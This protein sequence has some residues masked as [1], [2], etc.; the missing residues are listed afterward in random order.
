MLKLNRYKL[1]IEYCGTRYF[2]MQ[3]QKKLP[4]IESKLIDAISLFLNSK[5]EIQYSGRTDRGVHAKG[6]VIHFDTTKELNEYQIKAGINYYLTQEDIVIL[7]VEKV[8]LDF[9]ARFSAQERIYCYKILNRT[10][11][12]TFQKNLS[13][14]FRYRLDVEKMR[15]ASKYLIGKHDF[16]AFRSS[17][18]QKNPIKTLNFIKIEKQEDVIEFK[19]GAKS[20]LHNMVR[21][22]V[23][24]LL[25]I[26]RGKIAP[27]KIQELLKEKTRINTPYNAPACGLYFESVLY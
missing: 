27:E 18:C 14:H 7:N 10:E 26:G 5:I 25:E 15:V 8:D 9:H 11:R 4:T 19:I 21:I 24:V 12:L 2:G 16:S 13:Y 3:F 17:E 6:Q 1:T 23:A 20:F 22:I